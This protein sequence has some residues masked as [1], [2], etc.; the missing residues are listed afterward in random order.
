MFC[1][2]RDTL[3]IVCM[4]SATSI[5]G[6]VAIFS[7]LGF[8]ATQQGVPVSEVADKGKNMVGQF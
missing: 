2:H 5:Y 6:G 1:S 4:N 3:I 7:V 8:M